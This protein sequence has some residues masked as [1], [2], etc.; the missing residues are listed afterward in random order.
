MK[1]LTITVGLITCFLCSAVASLT[2][3]KP[4]EEWLRWTR[5]E[6]EMPTEIQN[7]KSITEIQPFLDSNDQFTRMAA[8]K[9]L[10]QLGGVDAVRLLYERFEKE[11]YEESGY[12]DPSVPIVKLEIIRS[13]EE[14]GGTE[15][16]SAL[17]NMLK[18]YWKNGP[19]VETGSPI[20]LD[21][22]FS[23]VVPLITDALY[24][25]ADSDDIFEISKTIV[26]SEILKKCTPHFAYPGNFRQNA[27]KLYLKGYVAH[28]KMSEK[29]SAKYLLDLDNNVLKKGRFAGEY[30][31]TKA[32]IA[33]EILEE[34]DESILS[35][36]KKDLEEE[37]EQKQGRVNLSKMASE[38][39]HDYYEFD[40]RIQALDYLLKKKAKQKAK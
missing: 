39:E 9:R 14:N 31:P 5:G 11:P 18:K 38:K 30:E 28:Q 10:G 12:M 23:T 32:A 19:K 15:A 13:L 21:G 16:K 3:A 7:V 37:R 25:W 22:D 20:Y 34:Y 1:R 24:K 29:N 2:Y 17:L 4:T 8:A 40:S 36:L 6:F 26:D 35:S 27:W 33:R